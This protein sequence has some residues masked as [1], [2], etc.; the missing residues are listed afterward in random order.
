[1]SNGHGTAKIIAALDLPTGEAALHFL[2][3]MACGTNAGACVSLEY[4][5]VGPRLFALEGRRFVE[6]LVRDGYKVFLDLKLHDIPNTVAGA[7][8]ALAGLGLWA[9]TLHSGGGRE[10]LVAAANARDAAGSTMHLL[11]V[12]VLTSVDDA[13]WKSVGGAAPWRNG[14]L[15]GPA[16]RR[17]G[18]GRLVCSPRELEAVR[19]AVGGSL[20]TVVPG[21]RP[22]AGGDDQK[23]TAS[24]ESPFGTVRTI[25][26]WDVRSWRRRIRP[27]LEGTAARHGGGGNTMNGR[28]ESSDG[29]HC[30]EGMA[31]GSDSCSHGSDDEH[32]S[33]NSSW[34]PER[35]SRDIF[36]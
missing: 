16:L 6:G 10:M 36:F 3:K 2:E 18:R 33:R 29:C 24:A 20:L 12:S 1:M 31:C 23:R 11:G 26:W 7:V 35:F 19:Q 28:E 32:S 4:V 15:A 22:V 9:L 27:D 17:C 5:K 14:G 8:D 25:S 21:I 13:T 34:R 30:H